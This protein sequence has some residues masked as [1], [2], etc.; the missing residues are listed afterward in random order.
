MS[1]RV[2]VALGI[3]GAVLFFVGT[4]AIAMVVQYGARDAFAIMGRNLPWMPYVAPIAIVL[5]L[6]LVVTGLTRREADGW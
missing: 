2:V 6:W 3:V 4:A 5:V 1:E